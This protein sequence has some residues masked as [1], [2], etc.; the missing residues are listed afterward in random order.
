[1]TRRPPSPGEGW[2]VVP[3]AVWEAAVPLLE[4]TTPRRLA[5]CRVCGESTTSGDVCGRC[6]YKGVSCGM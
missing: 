4:G 2:V 1:M 6:Y 5:P 3:A